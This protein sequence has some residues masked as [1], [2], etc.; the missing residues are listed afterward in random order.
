MS[1]T[2]S[3]I[4]HG[5]STQDTPRDQ[6]RQLPEEA[7]RQVCDR[8]G[9]TKQREKSR[10]GTGKKQYL[11]QLENTSEIIKPFLLAVNS[12]EEIQTHIKT[13]YLIQHS[14]LGFLFS[15]TPQG[16]VGRKYFNGNIPDHTETIYITLFLQKHSG[17]PTIKN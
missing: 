3:S 6:E 11:L 4:N 1:H 17:F 8:K 13:T 16:T 12:L 5:Q 10:T 14:S 15:D 9:D 7:W 2:I